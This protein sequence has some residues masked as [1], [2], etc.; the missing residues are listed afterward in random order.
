M[1]KIEFTHGLKAT[2]YFRYKKNVLNKEIVCDLNAMGHEIGYHYEVC[3]RAKG[4]MQN[5]EKIA[6]KELAELRKIVP[7]TSASMH[8]RPFSRWN[9]IDL[10]KYFPREHF[11]LVG[12]AYMDI[13]YDQVKYFSDTGRTWHSSRYNVRDHVSEKREEKKE[14]LNTY[15]LINVL[16]KE[17]YRSV[18]IL[19]H[20]ERWA[21]N[22]VTWS[23]SWLSDTFVNQA[24]I[25]LLLAR[26]L[27]R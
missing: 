13:D 11:G 2:Y 19:A 12:E 10:W 16:K 25:A 27:K 14:I 24:K 21:S 17:E 18:C 7:V 20:P 5:A 3:S 15:D 22:A 26:R 1:A 9:N 8:G 6:Q 4:N 23:A